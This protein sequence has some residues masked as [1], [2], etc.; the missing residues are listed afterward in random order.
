[1]MRPQDIAERALGLMRAQGFDAAQVDASRRELTELNIAL[2]Q[3]SLLRS[4][5]QHRLLLAG[6]V[7]GRRASTELTRLEDDHLRQTI[8]ALHAEACA[9]PQDAAHALSAGER[10]RIVQGPLAVEP[11]ALA[12]QL[13]DAV[14][15]LLAFRAEHT[16]TMML[17][18]G[19]ASYTR[20]E[21]HTLTT[22]GS[23]LSAHL[24]WYEL[25][26]VGNAREAG[27]SSSF[28]Y[29][30]GH[31]HQLAGPA[32]AAQVGI[33]T[34]MRDLTRQT[35]PQ[36]LGD[37]FVGEV[38]LTPM[39]V[40]S[41]LD[42]LLAQVG[43]AHL[44]A[45]SSV[46]RDQVGALVASP[47]L[48]LRSRF[49]APGV[50]GLSADAFAAR[51]VNLLQQGR[52]T[53]L[54]PTLY[55]SRKTGLPHHPAAPAGWALDAGDTALESLLG[56]VQRGAWVGRL[57]MGM[58]AANGDF[59]GVIKNSF[60]IE[61]GAIGRALSETMVTGNIAQMLRDVLAVSRERLDLG[62]HCVPWLRVGGL[63][64]S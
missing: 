60:A 37:K 35:A 17:Q 18:E 64:F 48:T 26:A 58:P 56:A 5:E 21:Q 51:P 33:D 28:S 59:S 41:L 16:P 23:D 12:D 46:L 22:G 7:D 38:L 11:M 13:A 39:A 50:V 20:L 40:C 49:D 15:G 19:L 2:N 25:T 10:A 45:G 42:W 24:A 32:S 36:P 4:T 62:A 27:R 3:P 52:L 31:T 61:G 44:I 30:G 55:G 8:A 54:L 63:R 9:A 57:S 34:M 47:L 1:M 29:A 6:L 43:D 14:S 53:S